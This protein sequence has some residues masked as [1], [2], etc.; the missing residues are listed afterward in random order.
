MFLVVALAFTGLAA[1][2]AAT[3]GWPGILREPVAI[4][5]PDFGVVLIVRPVPDTADSDTARATRGATE[6]RLPKP[7]S[8]SGL[9]PAMPQPTPKPRRRGTAPTSRGAVGATT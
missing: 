5:L 8:P 3:F 7:P 6:P 2:L 1:I 4:I 9:T